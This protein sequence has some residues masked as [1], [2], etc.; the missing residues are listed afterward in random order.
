MFFKSTFPTSRNGSP[1]GK[2]QLIQITKPGPLLGLQM[3]TDYSEVEMNSSEK[4]LS[5][6]LSCIRDFNVCEVNNAIVNLP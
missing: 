6:I 1:N 4:E 5:A 3:D 2:F